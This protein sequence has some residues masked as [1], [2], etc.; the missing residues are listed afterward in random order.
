MF[1]WNNNGYL[2]I[3]TTQRKFFDDGFIGTDVK[4]GVSF[5]ELEKIADAYGVSYTRATKVKELN[6]VI[7]ETLETD[8]PVI[9]EV[10]CKEWDAVLP[11]IGSKK[12]PNGKMFSRPLE[13]M[14]PFLTREEFYSNMIVK[15][16]KEN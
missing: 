6:E 12:L 15:P 1:V 4:S 3:R 2:S 11:T 7:T 5:P 14:F 16:L 8:G 9:C 13:D 10:M